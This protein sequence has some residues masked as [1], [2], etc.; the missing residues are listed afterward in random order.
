MN[1]PETTKEIDIYAGKGDIYSMK[2]YYRYLVWSNTMNLF[3][4]KPSQEGVAIRE[5]GPVFR[6][7]FMLYVA[8]L[9]TKPNKVRNQ[10][11]ATRINKSV[12]MNVM[13]FTTSSG[14]ACERAYCRIPSV[15]IG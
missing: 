3:L 9:P 4:V 13:T 14:G 11:F 1:N 15:D 7:R 6:V 2:A 12:K 10:D 5:W 8:S